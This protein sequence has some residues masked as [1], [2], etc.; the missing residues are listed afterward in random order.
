M[1]LCQALQSAKDG[2]FVTNPS[3]DSSQSLHYF[4]GKFYYEDGAVLSNDFIENYLKKQPWA[5]VNT[6]SVI[7]PKEEVDRNKLI[8]MHRESRGLMLTDKS[9]MECRKQVEES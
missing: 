2:N 7:I 8:Q 4:N 6:W 1:D 5:T 3:F 9:Y